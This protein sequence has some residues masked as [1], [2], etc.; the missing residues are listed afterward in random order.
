MTM[1]L[2]LAPSAQVERHRVDDARLALIGECLPASMQVLDAVGARLVADLLVE[3]VEAGWTPA[4]IREL[5]DQP[6]PLRVHRMAGLVASRLRDNVAVDQAP[7][8]LEEA[9]AQ[10]RAE[11]ERTR[12][13]ELE[14]QAETVD[15][16]FE[17]VWERVK[18]EMPDAGYTVWAFEAANAD[19]KSVV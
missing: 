14:T 8:R 2:P 5:L 15:P 7:R 16:V 13:E 1:T 10:R 11:R 4:Q 17:A 12:L 19:R 9:A 3:R 6:L 18:A